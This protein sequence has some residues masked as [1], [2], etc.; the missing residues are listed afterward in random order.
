[1]ENTNIS[2][3]AEKF[4]NFKEYLWY[5]AH[6]TELLQRFYGRFLAIKDGEVI[7]DY[8]SRSFAR[9]Q[10]CLNHEFGTFIIQHCVENVVRRMP[11]L[12]NFQI[13]TVN[14]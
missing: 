11:R 1:M 7:G 13:V 6:E 8:S 2:Y 12:H 4:P 10:T 3:D 5:K 14:E 9:E